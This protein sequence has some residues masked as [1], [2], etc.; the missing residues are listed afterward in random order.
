MALDAFRGVSR[1]VLVRGTGYGDVLVGS[2]EPWVG[3]GVGGSVNGREPLWAMVL[4][5][6]C[7]AVSQVQGAFKAALSSGSVLGPTKLLENSLKPE[8]TDKLR[9][10]GKYRVGMEY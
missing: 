6:P 1:C 3:G 5:N 8:M 9:K 2:R 10:V 4:R 7:K